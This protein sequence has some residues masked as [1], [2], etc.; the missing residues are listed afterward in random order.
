MD[1]DFDRL[2]A[3]ADH[4]VVAQ[5]PSREFLAKIRRCG[6]SVLNLTVAPEPVGAPEAVHASLI[7]A[8]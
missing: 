1:L 2:V 5:K 7:P 4:V 8:R 6:R 3:W